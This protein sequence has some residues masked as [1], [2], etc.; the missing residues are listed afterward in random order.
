MTPVASWE[1][2]FLPVSTSEMGASNHQQQVARMTAQQCWGRG[3]T[4]RAR[5]LFQG[6]GDPGFSFPT[7]PLPWML[8]GNAPSDSS[9]QY[10]PETSLTEF[11]TLGDLVSAP[12]LPTLFPNRESS[13]YFRPGFLFTLFLEPHSPEAD[14][15]AGNQV[16]KRPQLSKIELRL[17]TR[18]QE[19]VVAPCWSSV[20]EATVC[21]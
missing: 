11:T 16:A 6:L 20:F 2:S 21:I 5:A 9:S 12:P 19:P 10:P 17:R 8:T 7:P 1:T 4:T 15:G 3:R 13:S 14:N 18:A